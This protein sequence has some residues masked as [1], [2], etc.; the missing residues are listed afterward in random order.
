VPVTSGHILKDLG[1]GEAPKPYV[2]YTAC[3][4]PVT[5][6]ANN[7]LKLKIGEVLTLPH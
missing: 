4:I 6:G 1:K 3:P 7:L 5:Y 2:G